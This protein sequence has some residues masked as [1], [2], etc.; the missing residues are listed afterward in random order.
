MGKATSSWYSRP[1]S[2]SRTEI[3]GPAMLHLASDSRTGS[4]PELRTTT[5]DFKG[6]ANASPGIQTCSGD[7]ATT[8]CTTA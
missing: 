4:G 2:D 7:T 5:V 3:V 8:G 1:G 6:E